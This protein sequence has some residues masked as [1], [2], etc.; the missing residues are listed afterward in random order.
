M[1]EI[2]LYSFHHTVSGELVIEPKQ[3]WYSLKQAALILQVST[4][5]V[6][7]AIKANRLAAEAHG[8]IHKVGRWRISYESLRDA[9]SDKI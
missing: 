9:L 6:L 2:S 4:V 8:G 7:R 1:I 3:E 5:T